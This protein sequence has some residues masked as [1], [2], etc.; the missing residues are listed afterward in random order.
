MTLSDAYLAYEKKRFQ[1]AERLFRQVLHE[2]PGNGLARLGLART[3]YRLRCYDAAAT[4][5]KE[6]LRFDPQ[7]AESYTLLG[8]IACQRGDYSDAEVQLGRA[9]EIDPEQASTY[10][11]L[12]AVRLGQSRLQEAIA[13]AQRALELD[14]TSG[15]AY[16]NLH[17]TYARLG[18]WIE[19]ARAGRSAFR[20]LRSLEALV[21]MILAHEAKYLILILAALPVLALVVLFA[22]VR[23]SAPLVAAWCLYHVLVA[24]GCLRIRLW[25]YGLAKLVSTVLL[26]VLYVGYVMWRSASA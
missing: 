19:S 6:V 2:D 1:D 4:E 24:L 22:D 11:A 20:L 10:T 3:L 15:T 17:V 7:S 21:G 8:A 23:Y 18:R 14:P 12:A 5:A 13:A 25:R 26:L 16:Y 9:L